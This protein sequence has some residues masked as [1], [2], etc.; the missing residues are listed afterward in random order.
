MFKGRVV[1][2]FLFCFIYVFGLQGAYAD[3]PNWKADQD[4]L[5]KELGV[6]SGDAI[7]KSKK[8]LEKA[9]KLLP[10]KLYEWFARG[11][12][13]DL[14]IKAF[15]Y[16]TS[17]DEYWQKKSRENKGKYAI[18]EEGNMVDVSTGKHPVFV[19][20]LPFSDS[21]IGIDIPYSGQ[22]VMYNRNLSLRRIEAQRHDHV[23]LWVDFDRGLERVV[24]ASWLEYYYWGRKGGPVKN[25]EGLEFR[26]LN[27]AYSPFDMAGTASISFRTLGA[28]EDQLYVYVPSIRRVKRLSGA[29][30][31]D[32]YMGSECTLDDAFGWNGL[33]ASMDWKYKGEKA[34]LLWTL[35]WAAEH[36]FQM[37]QQADG[38][39]VSVT[40][41]FRAGFETPGSKCATW[42]PTNSV[43]IPR[44]FHVFEAM[45]KDPYYASGKVE[46]WVDAESNQVSYKFVYDKSGKF[47]KGLTLM[48]AHVTWAD[49][50]GKLGALCHF[51]CDD[52]LK[53]ATVIRG[54]CGKIN[55]S[56]FE[57]RN[58]F[59]S[60]KITPRALSVEKMKMLTK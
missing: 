16:D 53:H 59:N 57:L 18:T 52:K 42:A 30:R 50:Y 35:D 21:E 46:Y 47:W 2:F 22:K 14:E 25:P 38:S 7:T 43:W 58:V 8:D 19:N 44:M 60:R 55:D 15:K 20:G 3:N 1:S 10:E 32:P 51:T 41:P 40:P 49:S 39:W 4:A 34:S 11:D 27:V 5:F 54:G 6:K 48:T 12:L 26:S 23:I 37:E 36:S 28:K 33:I 17:D 45:P 29:N 9:K 31:S 13:M 24:Q 56:V